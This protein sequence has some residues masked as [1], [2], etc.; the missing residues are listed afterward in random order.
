MRQLEEAREL[1]QLSSRSRQATSSAINLSQP[2]ASLMGFIKFF[3]DQ[4]RFEN[5]I[6][7]QGDSVI[8]SITRLFI[9]S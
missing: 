5:I 7:C 6:S 4:V 1:Q 2:Q 8:C 3:M 9:A